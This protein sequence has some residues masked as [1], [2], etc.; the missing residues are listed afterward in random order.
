MKSSILKE[1]LTRKKEL[2]FP[3]WLKYTNPKVILSYSELMP[4]REYKNIYEIVL[5]G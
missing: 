4:N 2:K 3:I 5:K 1:C